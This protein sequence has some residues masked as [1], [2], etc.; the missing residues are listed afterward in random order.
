MGNEIN[1]LVENGQWCK[2]WELVKGKVWEL[3]KARFNTIFGDN[4]AQLVGAYS[5]EEVKSDV[6]S[7]DNVK[8]LGQRKINF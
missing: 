4:N 7:C 1:G 6:W 3:F 5:T 8:S 2:D